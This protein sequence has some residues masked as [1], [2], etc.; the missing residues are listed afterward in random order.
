MKQETQPNDETWLKQRIIIEG[1]D[2]FYEHLQ[3][4][5]DLERAQ[6]DYNAEGS[7]WYSATMAMHGEAEPTDP[8]SGKR[9][10]RVLARRL[11]G[12]DRGISANVDSL[13]LL[14]ASA[15][16]LATQGVG[17]QSTNSCLV[18]LFDRLKPSRDAAPTRT[19]SSGSRAEDRCEQEYRDAE[20]S[21]RAAISAVLRLV[22]STPGSAQEQRQAAIAALCCLAVLSDRDADRRADRQN[23]LV[24]EALA[25]HHGF[26]DWARWTVRQLALGPNSPDALV[27]LVATARDQST[28]QL[29]T[30]QIESLRAL[31][32]QVSAVLARRATTKLRTLLDDRAGSGIAS[33]ELRAEF[34]ESRNNVVGFCEELWTHV[35]SQRDGHGL[36]LDGGPSSPAN[37]FVRGLTNLSCETCESKVAEYLALVESGQDRIEDRLHLN[38]PGDSDL[39]ID[40]QARSDE[41]PDTEVNANLKKPPAEAFQAHA[42]YLYSGKTQA[43][44]ADDMTRELGRKVGQHQISRWIKAIKVWHAASNPITT[45]EEFANQQRT[46]IRPVD[47]HQLT[48]GPRQDGRR[49]T[50]PPEK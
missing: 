25:D 29:D 22:P 40:D 18:E 5:R 2:A 23:P 31:L 43:E 50:R 37:E 8:E 44:C 10:W 6:C 12:L 7:A 38:A 42:L 41:R 30:D 16:R 45:L 17:T 32:I 15:I 39:P 27:T 33:S 47:P 4:F 49:A 1:A 14:T 19:L 48:R 9:D 46:R 34:I 20:R 35:H 26:R 36:R 24:Q 3:L 11:A 21:A 28:G 13:G